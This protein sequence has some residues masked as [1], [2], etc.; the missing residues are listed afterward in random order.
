MFNDL[1]ILSLKEINIF[2]CYLTVTSYLLLVSPQVDP[3]EMENRKSDQGAGMGGGL[4]DA[5]ARALADRNKVIQG[6]HKK[7]MYHQLFGLQN[8]KLVSTESFS[9]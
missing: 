2:I 1:I 8:L 6:M 4:A 5:L 3:S 9:N 7:Y